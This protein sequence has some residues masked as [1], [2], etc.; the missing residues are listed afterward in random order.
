MKKLTVASFVFLC[1]CTTAPPSAVGKYGDQ[2][3]PQRVPGSNAQGSAFRVVEFSRD[4]AFEATKK[5]FLRLGY[6][7]EE[8]NQKIGKITGNGYFQCGGSLRP[9]VTIAVYAQQ[10]SKK[11]ETRVTII[12]DR[13]NYECWGGGEVRAADQMAVEIQKVLSTF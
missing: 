9:P 5:A 4:E 11:P 8:S 10:I 1:A 7:V 13:H 3:L 6:N 2:P 12:V